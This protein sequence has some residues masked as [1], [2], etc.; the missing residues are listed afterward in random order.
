MVGAL[1]LGELVRGPGAKAL[2]LR[3]LIEVVLAFVARG[4]GS[5]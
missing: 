3:A 4:G 2:A 5:A 1:E